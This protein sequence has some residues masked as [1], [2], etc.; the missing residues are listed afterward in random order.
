[1]VLTSLQA[2]P[3]EELWSESPCGAALRLEGHM[4]AI[5]SHNCP[6]PVQAECRA[7]SQ[8][9]LWSQQSV[10]RWYLG[11]EFE[12]QWSGPLALQ[13]PP[14]RACSAHSS[15][16]GSIRGTCR[17]HTPAVD[18][19]G[20]GRHSLDREVIPSCVKRWS[21]L[22]RK[23]VNLSR[24]GCRGRES[25]SFLWEV[26]GRGTAHLPSVPPPDWSGIPP[27][28]LTLRIWK[29]QGTE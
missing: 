27:R 14:S 19:L 13:R 26:L 4:C 18:R 12:V 15:R 25:S 10:W 7:P 9:A 21:G 1:M 24:K 3:L 16:L 23:V 17:T 28:C 29:L 2:W 8:S 20:T 22:R 5:V 11:G 6:I